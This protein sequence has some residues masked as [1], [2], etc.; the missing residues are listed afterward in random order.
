MNKDLIISGNK[1]DL[2]G[3]SVYRALPTAKRR[4]IGP[5]VFIDHM[6][7]MVLDET[8]LLNVRPHPHIGLSTVTYLF[9]GRGF[10][11][12]SIGSSQVI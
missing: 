11:R 3:F 1:K 4:Q 9:E 8:H 7:P 12:D 2:G 5:F 10:H 6:G